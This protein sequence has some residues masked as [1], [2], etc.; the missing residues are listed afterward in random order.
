MNNAIMLFTIS[1]AVCTC[2][3]DW[4]IEEESERVKVAPNGY[5][6]RCRSCNH[7]GEYHPKDVKTSQ[8]D[9]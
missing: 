2:L 4:N 5:E 6:V 8:F 7:V 1:C 9:R 3:N